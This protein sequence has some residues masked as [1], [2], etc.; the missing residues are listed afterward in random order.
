[1]CISF[2]FISIINFNFSGTR[3]EVPEFE[4]GLEFG[5]FGIPAAEELG[6]RRPHRQR[7]V[8]FA[9]DLLQAVLASAGVAQDKVG[10]CQ[11]SFVFDQTQRFI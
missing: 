4:G 5:P 2:G 3:K 9:F 1:M 7:Q 11:S 6:Q 8:Q 10:I